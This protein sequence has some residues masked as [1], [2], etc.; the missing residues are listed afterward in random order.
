MI[1]RN[2]LSEPR[3]RGLSL[4]LDTV[5]L[6]LL[7]AG[8]ASA[9]G[10]SSGLAKPTTA[11]RSSQTSTANAGPL[12]LVTVSADRLA[13]GGITLTAPPQSAVAGVS[14]AT[15]TTNATAK[16]PE[17]GTAVRDVQLVVLSD[18]NKVPPIDGELSYAVEIDVPPGSLAPSNG[19]PSLG[20]NTPSSSM[21]APTETWFVVFVDAA[22]GNVVDNL[23]G[24]S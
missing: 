13:S 1:S 11:P 3:S 16:Y 19:Q 20:S 6:S 2:R 12:S 24:G 7:V 22:N 18:A 9:C 23:G 5:V 21:P 17:Y 15:A 14:Q 4:R 10:T 8:V